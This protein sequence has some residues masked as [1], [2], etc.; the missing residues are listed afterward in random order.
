VSYRLAVAIGKFLPPH[1]GH[2]LLIDTASAQ[3]REVVVIVCAKPTD[4]IPG[5]LRAR[6]LQE[7]HPAARV[8]TI[9]D[10][11]DEQDSRVWA[12]NTV[13]WLGRAPDAVFS[14]EAYGDAYASFMG[15]SHV[16]VDR[17]RRRVPISG[18]QLR[19][20]PYSSWDFLEPPVRAWY[21][22]RVCVL[23]A[24]STGTTTLA[25]AL[26]ERL[27]TV[28]VG[29]FGRE[30]SE[31]KRTAGDL[32]WRS[33]EFTAIAAEQAR[34]EDL[35]ARLANRVLIC[36]TNAFATVLWHRRHMGSHSEAVAEIARRGRCDLYLLTGD[37]IP[38][39]Q[40]GLRD[41]EQI[42]HEMH[43]WFETAL[44]DQPVPWR[45]LRGAHEQRLREAVHATQALFSGSAWSPESARG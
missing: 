16:S 19:R 27:G 42:R 33:D 45:L 21:A 13:R 20:D 17:D 31:Q 9:D 28:W 25:R 1:R 5:A 40:D 37:E 39:V 14:S 6:W 3:S 43:R 32:D 29:E 12:E 4:A 15:A 36:D 2:K 35:A 34:R 8:M 41:G 22:K 44:E 23:G 11:Y 18:T 38:F 10:H 7:I 26:A 24:E 30:R